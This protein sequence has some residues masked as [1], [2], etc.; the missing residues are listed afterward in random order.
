MR[1]RFKKVGR[2]RRVTHLAEF[3]T[4]IASRLASLSSPKHLVK[5]FFDHHYT[6]PV[7][8]RHKKENGS[9]EWPIASGEALNGCVESFKS[10]ARNCEM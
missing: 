4:S 6:S 8:V 3:G 10:Q 7:V 1:R 9:K 2:L 5:R